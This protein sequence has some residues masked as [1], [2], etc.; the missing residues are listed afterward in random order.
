MPL[1]RMGRRGQQEGGE[2]GRDET[3]RRGGRIKSRMDRNGG[4]EE[5]TLEGRKRGTGR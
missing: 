5:A 1:L 2:E 3:G 4:R